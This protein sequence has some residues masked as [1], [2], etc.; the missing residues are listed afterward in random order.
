MEHCRKELAKL[1]I[2]TDML[3]FTASSLDVT[4][5]GNKKS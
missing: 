4:I 3:E 1:Y 5:K 2:E